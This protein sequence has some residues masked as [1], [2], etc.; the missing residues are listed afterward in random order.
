MNA[1][2]GKVTDIH[3]TASAPIRLTWKLPV[4][5]DL[6]R[7]YVRRGPAGACPTTLHQGIQIGDAALRSAQAD[8]A[9]TQGKA[10]CYAI[11]VIDSAGQTTR[12]PAYARYA[13]TTPPPQVVGVT[14][15]PSRTAIALSWQPS[16]G[17]A[18]YL[19]YRTSGGT[20]STASTN[21]LG[22]VK[23]GTSYT[24]N[25]AQ[26]GVTYC[27]SVV[28]VDRAGNASAAASSPSEKLVTPPAPPTSTTRAT[29]AK[30]SSGLLGSSIARLAAE[31]G[32][33][34]VIFGLLALLAVRLL[35]R[36]HG[37]SWEYGGGAFGTVRGALQ[38][39]DTGALVIPL[40]ILVI[41]LVL[42]GAAALTL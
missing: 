5:N 22:P 10:Y 33:G 18:T 29:P 37:D 25:T 21:L 39:Y 3:S 2:P 41:G 8:K 17:A 31:V 38:R 15:V 4:A 34:I 36:L 32:S 30:P 28:A 20:C 16:T 24:D 35:P 11:I 27:Y 7:V 6:A 12:T 14:A 1:P 26:P 19:V 23:G 40:V 13:D 42:L 9:V